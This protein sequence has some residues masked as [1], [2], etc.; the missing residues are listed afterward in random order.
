MR[1][2]WSI[3]LLSSLFIGAGLLHFI[4]P[5]R[6]EEIV[7]P[8]LPHASWIVRLSG[9]AEIIGGIGLLISS[10]RAAAG[11]GLI[12]LLVAVFP[13][14][15]Q[16][17]SMAMHAAETSRLWLVALWVRLPLQA[18]MIWWVFQSAIRR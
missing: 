11:W 9:I 4:L 7:P 13:A 6:Y 1:I 16:M 12:L 2:S 14:N 17:L 5:H 3:A 15:V 10:T 8:W 18:A